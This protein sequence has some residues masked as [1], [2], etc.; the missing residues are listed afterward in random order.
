MRVLLIVVLC[1][2]SHSTWAG[3]SLSDINIKSMKARF[4]DECRTRSC[5]H[6]K[7]VA[8]LTNRCA[9]AVGVQIKI[10]A[11]DKTGAPLATRDLWPASI[12]NIPP[13][14]Y[15]FSLDHWLDYDPDMKTFK[16]NV[17]AIKQWR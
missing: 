8:V 12:N 7:G 16:L 11:Y 3:C 10:T 15:T 9:E 13:G 2:M 17:I 6:M 1:S 4:V 14:D 5:P